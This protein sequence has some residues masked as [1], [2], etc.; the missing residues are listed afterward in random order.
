MDKYLITEVESSVCRLHVP[1]ALFI[2]TQTFVCSAHAFDVVDGSFED[3]AFVQ[4]RL[5]VNKQ[6][7]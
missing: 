4:T 1:H 5:S 3:G 7:T 2:L 6:T